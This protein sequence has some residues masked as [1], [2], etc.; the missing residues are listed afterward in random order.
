MIDI[1]VDATQEKETI[2]IEVESDDMTTLAD[3][4][5][6]IAFDI[7]ALAL[8]KWGEKGCEDF[9]QKFLMWFDVKS[10]NF[11]RKLEEIKRNGDKMRWFEYLKRLT[12][13]KESKDETKM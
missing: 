11:P 1:K 12:N 9:K 5:A 10:K 8:L 3:E 7:M 2:R 6:I 13:F 4:T